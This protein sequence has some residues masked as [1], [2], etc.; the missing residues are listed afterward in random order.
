VEVSAV[1]GEGTLNVVRG[2]AK[3]GFDLEVTLNIAIN[4]QLYSVVASDLTDYDDS[5]YLTFKPNEKLTE[6]IKLIVKQR[7]DALLTHLKLILN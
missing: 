6:D 5:A 7:S 3:I 2:R 1:T 4:N